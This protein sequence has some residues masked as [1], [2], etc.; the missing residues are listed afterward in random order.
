[1]VPRYQYR[2][3]HPVHS[4]VLPLLLVLYR[5]LPTSILPYLQVPSLV[6]SHLVR[7]SSPSTVGG[8][9]QGTRVRDVQQQREYDKEREIAPVYNPYWITPTTIDTYYTCI[10]LYSLVL[11]Q[12][13]YP[14]QDGGVYLG[15]QGVVGVYL[16]YG[17]YQHHSIIPIPTGNPTIPLYPYSPPTLESPPYRSSTWQGIGSSI[18][19]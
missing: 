18:G 5:L 13:Y 14:G 2:G 15:Q 17:V 7:Y 16:A 1:M 6:Y 4:M 3:Y 11:V 10:S 9:Q 19:R 12:G 8:I